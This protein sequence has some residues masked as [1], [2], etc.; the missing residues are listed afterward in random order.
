MDRDMD[1]DMDTDTDTDTDMN[2]DKDRDTN[3]DKDTDMDKDMEMNRE[4]DMAMNM[5]AV[6]V[7]TD[8]GTLNKSTLKTNRYPQLRHNVATFLMPNF[9]S[10]KEY[11]KQER[12]VEFKNIIDIRLNLD[13][14]FLL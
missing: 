11:Q 2:M 3:R 13:T 10:L 8:D 7:R 5:N 4:M 14:S 6:K 1:T 12:K 9:D